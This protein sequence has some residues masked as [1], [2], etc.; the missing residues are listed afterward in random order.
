[1]AKPPGPRKGAKYKPF[2]KPEAARYL[3]ELKRAQDNFADF[4]RFWHPNWELQSFQLDLITK[5]DRFE[6]G[7][8]ETDNLLVT[9][10]PR[11]A[12]STFCTVL[13]PTWF[14]GRDPSRFVMSCSYNAELATGFGRDI[15]SI[16]ED[17]RYAQIFP[18]LGL[19]QESR[20]ADHWRTTEHGAYYAVGIGGTTSGRPANL[21]IFDDPIK[22]REEAER[23]TQRNRTWNYYV[24]A[25]TT[26]L[27]PDNTGNRPK[28]IV[29]LTRWHPDDV[30]G[31][32]QRS[33]DWKEGRWTHVNYPA[34]R[35]EPGFR[36]LRS[37]LPEDHPKYVPG[38]KLRTISSHTREIQSTREVSAWP[39]RFPLEDLERRRRL[40]PREFASLY[41]QQ[42]YVEGG[43]LIKTEWWQFYPADLKPESFAQVIIPVDTAFKKNE[44]NDYSVALTM[45]LDRTGDI[46]IL[47]VMRGR[48]EF[49]ELKQRIITLNTQWRG[50]GLRAFYIEDRASGQS[51]I[52]SLRRESGIAL[53]PYKTIHDK[54]ARVNAVLP[55]IEGGRVFLPEAAPWLDDFMEECVQFPGSTHDDQVDALAIGLD[56]LAKTATSA[57]DFGLTGDVSQSLNHVPHD[58]FGKSLRKTL[59][60]PGQWKGWGL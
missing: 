3:L 49:P 43:N 56:V 55:L 4:V 48:Y 51:L 38:H 15:R 29:V 7:L 10:P 28:Q 39:E 35:E 22:A 26:R 16:V 58:A 13:F 46:Y 1:M 34:I 53:I 33:D 8:L 54:V 57:A 14:M 45:G 20:A 37:H 11:F 27:Q 24:S 42:P 31:R 36:I 60:T 50:R 5:L 17:P 12:K 21:L 19:S 25:L 9:M 41:Q 6:K 47:S 18:D 32:L 59:K 23:I 30:A 2:T 44:G 40:N 52:Q